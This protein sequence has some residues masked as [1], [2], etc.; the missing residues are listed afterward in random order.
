[1]FILEFLA[2]LI[3]NVD[4]L[5]VTKQLE[6]VDS[7]LKKFVMMEIHAQ[8]IAAIFKLETVDTL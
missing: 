3:I 8:S 4:H 7:L 6:D 1:V 2:V 5:I